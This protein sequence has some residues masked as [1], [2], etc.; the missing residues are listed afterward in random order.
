LITV[1]SKETSLE[2]NKNKKLSSVSRLN[3]GLG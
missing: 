1:I 3:E 2:K